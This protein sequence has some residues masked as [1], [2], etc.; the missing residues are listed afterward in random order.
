MYPMGTL[1]IRKPF[2]L[3]AEG[4]TNHTTASTQAGLLRKVLFK[5][6]ISSPEVFDADKFS[7]I[8]SK[9]A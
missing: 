9:S 1:P 4:G 3:H 8:N 6:D 2:D 7:F 5:N